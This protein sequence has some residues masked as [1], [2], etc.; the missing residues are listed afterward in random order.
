MIKLHANRKQT[1][2]LLFCLLATIFFFDKL[3]DTSSA[4]HKAE[5]RSSTTK[6]K[7][8]AK[9]A[10]PS[11]RQ[12]SQ[13]QVN[14]D[15]SINGILWTGETGVTETTADIMLR[16][17]MSLT[18]Q[19]KAK[20][21]LEREPESEHAQ[22]DRNNLPQNPLA[23]P[24][25]RWPIPEAGHA[26]IGGDSGSEKRLVDG[27]NFST[28]DLTVTP[29]PTL[30]FTAATL[31]ETSAFP[32]DTMGA[33]GPTQFLLAV[34][35]RIRV[36][37][38]NTGAK[39]ELDADI[40]S[41][42]SSVRAGDITTDPRVRYD[43][44]SGRW[45]IALINAASANNRIILAVSNSA[46][47]NST[48]IWTFYNF[49]HN[50]VAPS[51]DN[52]CF[53][54]YPTLGIDAHAL[55]IGVN[56]FCNRAFSNTTA[57]VIR[58]SSV[59]NG[60]P[61]VASAFR[62][63]IDSSG[64]VPGNGIFTP[65]GVDNFD[66]NASAG[67]FIGTD[68]NSFGRL[69]MRR[70][71][72]PGGAPVMSP[73]IYIN[74]LTTSA[75]LTVR[76]RGNFN[77]VNGRL[78]ALDDRLFAA[79]MRGESIWTAH[80][81]AVNN[82]GS[83]DA[84]RTR[85]GARW[86][87]IT[88]L[89]TISPRM[90]QAG[91][92]FAPTETN[93]E[94][95]RNYFIPALAVSG[96]GHMLIG[97]SAAGTNEYINAAIARRR[98][99]D[100]L[101]ITQLPRLITTSSGPYNPSSNSG[102][103]QGRRRWGDYS[104]TSID[105]CDDMTMWTVQQFSDATNSY[106]LRVAK[107]PAPP[108]A[109]PVSAD[110]PSI[111]PG[112]A[113]VNVTITGLPVEGAGFFDP[114]PGFDCRL[115]AAVSGGVTVNS[116]GYLNPTTVV[117]NLSTINATLGAKTV[118]IT[119]PDGQAVSG[120]NILTVGNCVYKVAANNQ[121][122]S[123]SGGSGI[124]SVESLSTCG[125]TAYSNVDFITINSDAI[126]TGTG[127]INFSVA[128]TVGG[129]RVGNIIVA[130]QTITIS[131]S[132][133][134]GCSFAVSPSTRNFLSTGGTGSFNVSTSN[135]CSWSATANDSFISILFV[136]AGQGNGTVS[137]AVSANS[138]P[139]TR[140]GSISVGG[141]VFT[142][143][144]DAAPFEL[145]VDDGVFESA[146]GVSTG[147]SSYRVNRLTPSFYPA[148]MNAVSVHFPDNNSVKLGDQFNVVVG[149]NPDGDANIDGT[150]FQT[151]P[152]QIQKVGE[153]NVVTIPSIT[154][155]QGDFVVG[156]QLNQIANAFPFSL[157]TTKSAS[158]SYRSLDGAVF[159]LI[160][161]IGTVGNYGIR[162][163][164]VRPP[165]LMMN[166]G[167]SLLVESCLPA[168]RVIDPGETVT[169]NLS[170]G[171]I[172]SNSTQNL[173]AT[174]IASGNV[175]TNSQSQNYG[176]IAPGA[177]A[178]ARQ[179]TFTASAACGGVIPVKLSLK[180]GSEDLGFVT[181]NFVA[182]AIGNSVQT[183]SYAGDAVR[184]P[185]GDARGISLPLIVSGFPSNI[186]DLNFR[187]EG[188][189]CTTSPGATTVG[190]DHSWIGDLTFKLTSPSG[191]NVTIIN[192]PG[193][194]GNSGK[195]F[196]Q[197]VLDDDA[198]NAISINN[199]TSTGLPPQGPPYTGTFK[200]SNPLS[201]FDGE[202]P[203]GTWTLT[204]ID[205]S[206]GDTGNVR[207]FSL[208]ITGFACCSTGCLDVTGK[209]A[210]SGAIGSQVMIT[211]SG[212]VGVTSVK[213]GGVSAAFT[214]NS[215]TS[216]TAT[217][218]AGAQAAPI[219]LSKPG[220]VDAQ[221]L[222]FTAFP[223]IVIA[224]QNLIATAGTPTTLTVNLGYAQSNGTVLNLT[225]SN[226]SL[227]TVPSSVM[228]PAGAASTGFQI[229][230]VALGGPVTITAKLPTS[231]GGASATASVNVAART[232][233]AIN[234]A[235]S[236]GRTVSVPIVLE[237]KGDETSVKFSL[238]YNPLLLV[239]PQIVATG[240]SAGAQFSLNSSQ[241]LQGRI[242]VT[243]SQPA[244]QRFA[245]GMRQVAVATFDLPPLIAPTN[246]TIDFADQPVARSITGN[247][248][249]TI[250]AQFVAGSIRIGLGF[251][252][253]VSPRPSGQ[254]NGT[255]TITD[256]VQIGRFVAGLDVAANGNEFQRADVSPRESLGDGRITLADWVQVG[257]YVAG[258]ESAA[259]AGGPT[260]PST[261][262]KPVCPTVN[263]NCDS[264]TFVRSGETTEKLLIKNH[265]DFLTIE[266]KA[267]GRENAI[268]FSLEFDQSEWRFVS[269]KA[270]RGA[271][272]A[273]VIVNSS[274]ATMGK[275]GLLVALP[276]GQ[277]YTAGGREVVVI[278]FAP[279]RKLRKQSLNAQFGD[280]PVVRSVIDVE[281]NP[282]H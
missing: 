194:S 185:D 213:F 217:V 229:V 275:I 92:I 196:C 166:S 178:V 33:V 238:N 230:G 29:T 195:N 128:P 85:N 139:V 191:T 116:V 134:G 226:P 221:T 236:I 58:K 143:T 56:Q 245:E 6:T 272:P 53:A 103:Q 198:A 183:F 237:S 114:G 282:L 77:G 170:L 34:N 44:L 211:G 104:F 180:D 144:Q 188:T 210:S 59:L 181:Y 136:S 225:S 27:L 205:G 218:P 227:V 50:L 242:G 25:A 57:F 75:P 108:P 253:D 208:Q 63:L 17:Q 249:A 156:I 38:K 219:V 131:Q 129:A 137:F 61:I 24:G 135:D 20:R 241:A 251:E 120:S 269:A 74:V 95:E 266:L 262:F 71:L 41:F 31:A 159:E 60:G 130:G 186:A 147:G 281:A 277:T 46:A 48:T 259:V 80:N 182:G 153:F 105:P 101:G 246:T 32:P 172:G 36:F 258:L 111:S 1:V 97:C 69:V 98:A 102:N 256:W 76:H 175:I 93:T 276:A 149:V 228:V 11:N 160:D 9:I 157:D 279:Q 110:P 47:I 204:V 64:T 21:R 248:G 154:I 151:I 96:Q 233:S 52:G 209:S 122:F 215:N 278:Q 55:Y 267:S 90:V 255:V 263:S 121:N 199:I 88:G 206:I 163:R 133:G 132:A 207:S 94:D 171:N 18:G 82:E 91:T 118:L 79:Q 23:L 70:V 30:S 265:L 68:A 202:N 231:L 223:G 3:S 162:A 145:S 193:G 35:G 113:S 165:K 224:P 15:G 214:I 164:L 100:P 86:Y 99:T 150:G 261:T 220:C 8:E 14:A 234:S 155:T 146:S 16:E 13:Q 78:D 67:Y 243:V 138:Q 280:F 201:A 39:G 142:V 141:K 250:A 2:F 184:I 174:L 37:N 212:F 51:G 203:N 158:R 10:N 19:T 54:D 161:S 197:T 22:P 125:W 273:T 148:T 107:I 187:I 106:G 274:Q 173:V 240:D 252:G 115:Q 119:N 112:V 169:V 109:R 72:N 12:N 247:N 4:Q 239:N 43:R 123:A 254:N 45:F 271:R 222:T 42:F 192:R 232:V 65:Q 190:V 66:P 5:R 81:I 89:D 235:G 62:N 83:V 257:R 124:I 167:A 189:S 200:P 179:F 244:G 140:T 73:N 176:A 270:G 152:A 40:D 28:A 268:S 84:P 264:A 177:P 7:S 168:N 26:E 216:I 127:T 126:G 87:E 260:S 117:L 49:Q